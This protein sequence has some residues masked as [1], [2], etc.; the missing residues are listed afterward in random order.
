M[1]ERERDE[2]LYLVCDGHGVEGIARMR[3]HD[4]ALVGA[5]GV[6]IILNLMMSPKKISLSHALV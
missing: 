3:R 6:V 2:G 5:C 1:R 4:R